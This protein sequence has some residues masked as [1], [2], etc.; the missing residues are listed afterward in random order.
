MLTADRLRELLDYDP[1]TGVFTWRVCANRNGALKGMRAGSVR[2][3]GYR[4][5]AIE[6]RH[7]LAHRLAWLH[8]HGAWPL[9]NIDHKNNTPGDDRIANL[10]EADQIG[11]G[12]NARR[13][14]HNRSGFKGASYHPLSGLWRARLTKCGKEHTS[15]HGTKEEAHIAY[16]ERAIRLS[17]EFANDG[18]RPLIEQKEVSAA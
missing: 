7:Y 14:S 12:A 16:C 17:G 13:P 8:V 4:N 1:K 15:Y 18:I 3:D 9:A 6:G 2:K 10:R 11:N 5:I